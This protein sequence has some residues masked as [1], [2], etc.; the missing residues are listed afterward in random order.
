MPKK[1]RQRRKPPVSLSDEQFL[2][3]LQKAQEHRVRD[4]ILILFTYCHGF[5]ASE[6]LAVTAADFD[7]K[8]G[9]VFVRRGKGSEGGWQDLMSWP[10]NP[11]L[12]E[13]T[14]IEYW[15]ANRERF[16]VKGGAKA[17]KLSAL[18][19]QLSVQK[20]QQ[21]TKI[22]TFLPE[23]PEKLPPGDIWAWPPPDKPAGGSEPLPD[24]SGAHSE[25]GNRSLGLSSANP[26][27][28]VVYTE[29]NCIPPAVVNDQRPTTDG[30]LFP[31]SRTQFWRLVHK[32]ALAAGIPKRKCKTHMLKHTIA[33]HL[34]RAGHPVNEIMEWMGWRSMETM[35]WYIRADEEE[36]GQRIGDRMRNMQGLRPARQGSLFRE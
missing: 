7:L 10:D 23:G 29:T 3:L 4:W 14:A 12:D 22:V 16:G 18:S 32:Y 24:P 9:K 28:N 1:P 13:R 19:S 5:R 30:R 8:E 15:L 33:K 11:L 20:M 17:K 35:M 6:P 21:S 31:I 34:V 36:L 26:T 27:K 25:T 2:A